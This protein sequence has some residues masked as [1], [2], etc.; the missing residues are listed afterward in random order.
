M[1]I[2]ILISRQ[3]LSVCAFTP[4][5]QQTLSACKKIY[6]ND[7]LLLT[8][9][10]QKT[11]NFQLFCGSLLKLR[12]RVVVPSI[13]QEEFKKNCRHYKN[14]FHLDDKKVE[15]V[16]LA[17][18]SV[19][20]NNYRRDQYIVDNADLI[21]PISIRKDGFFYNSLKNKKNIDTTFQIDYIVH[22]C[23]KRKKSYKPIDENKTEKLDNYLFHWTRMPK[24]NWPDE[25]QFD[26]YMS[27][28]K[29]EGTSR[30]AFDTLCNIFDKK[31]ICSSSRHA[32]KKCKIVSFTGVSIGQF[33]GLMKWRKKYNEM[34]FEPYG[35]G[36]DKEEATTI[37]FQKVLYCHPEEF[38]KLSDDEKKRYHSSGK[39]TNWS[40]EN[41]YRLFS[42]LDLNLIPIEKMICI[43]PTSDESIFIEKKY[44]IK[45]YSLY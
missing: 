35:I 2:S 29:K 34:S 17:S 37:G 4:W 43:C 40:E 23:E 41:E 33:F 26:Y 30:T 9:I 27:I 28:L 32:I 24:E 31:V 19:F 18:N 44:G 7:S 22:S 3:S 38:D 20:K 45:S 25:S 11:W 13:D 39:K 14:Q 12:M 1:L 6:E 10:G 42:D 36:I 8:S 5:I 16:F 21:F 15:F